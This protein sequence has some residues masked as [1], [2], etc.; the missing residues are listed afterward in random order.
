MADFVEKLW[1]G[2]LVDTHQML[3]VAAIL[4]C[5]EAVRHCRSDQLCE[6]SKIL[7]GGGEEE[8]V[9]GAGWTAQPQ[10]S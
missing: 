1:T 3:S 9:F 6:L 8:F 4:R 7:G 5:G 2:E 10:A